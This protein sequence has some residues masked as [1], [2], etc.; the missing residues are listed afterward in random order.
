MK[1]YIVT[2]I[3]SLLFATHALAEKVEVKG[4]GT[5]P[6]SGALF[7]KDPSSDEKKKA[8][9]AAKQSAWKS[10]VATFNISKQQML[11]ASEKDI[12]ANLDKFITEIQIIDQK[13]DK[14]L[15]VE[16]RHGQLQGGW[17][18]GNAIALPMQFV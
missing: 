8:I 11:A 6:Y 2:L 7:S 17:R 3:A 18:D 5:I 10:Y 1:K 4:I 12:N 15:F 13:I 16:G 9:E 14:R